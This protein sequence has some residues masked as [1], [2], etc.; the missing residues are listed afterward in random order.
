M[1]G[2]KT[3]DRIA[4]RI[5]MNG[6]LELRDVPVKVSNEEVPSLSKCNQ[7]FLYASGYWGPGYVTIKGQV[8]D[9]SL[10]VM[11]CKYLAFEIAE[12]WPT[13]VDFVAGNV[14]G[15]VVPGWE[16]SRALTELLGKTIPFVYIRELRKAGG[17]KEL[18]TGI[19]NVPFGSS[20]LDM[21]ELVNFAQTIRNGASCLEA[22]GYVAKQGACILYYDNPVADK[23]L[24]EA[25]IE[26][27]WLLTLARLL[28]SVESIG[29]VCA[30]G[31]DRHKCLVD[32]RQFLK[33]PM[34]WQADRGLTRVE[35]GGTK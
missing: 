21:E 20:G 12:K 15:G 19:Q 7:P 8:G 25:G 24:A 3:L 9:Q 16:V 30:I 27:V 4:T 11:L 28:D 23:E 14:T 34:Q 10:M 26:M 2:E 17:Q 18:I 1:I 6:A 13:G 29:E 33:D 22:A 31:L 35:K 32:Y 5:L